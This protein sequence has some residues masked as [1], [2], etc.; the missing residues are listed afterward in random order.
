MANTGV[1][2]L[3]L[4]QVLSDELQMYLSASAI[5]F[6]TVWNL[7]DKVQAGATT[8]AIPRVTGGNAGDWVD[9]G[10]DVA[11]AGMAI[12][13]DIMALDQFKQ[14][15]SYIY[16]T[17]RAKSSADLNDYFYEIAPSKLGD[18][19]ELYIYSEL[20]KASA[21]NPDNIFQLTGTGN[22]VPAVADIFTIAQLLDKANAPK[23][24]RFAAM[25]VAAYYALI[26]TDAI[27]NGSKSLSAEALVNGAFS[28]VAGVTLIYST[29]ITV[30]EVVGYQ[31]TAVAFAFGNDGQVMAPPVERQESKFRDFL[32]LKAQYGCKVLDSGKRC[33]LGNATGA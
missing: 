18:L 32:T 22:L 3:S 2:T 13:T 6:P 26:Q 21:S 16:D 24:D 19:I 33:V 8:V 1:T 20:K 31:K 11:D 4:A 25:G 27:I 29:N 10:S 23:M 30:G 14:Y 28:K 12:A 5:L 7:S 9:N 17:E 15:S